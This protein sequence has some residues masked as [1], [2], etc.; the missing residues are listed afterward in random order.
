MA[1][2]EFKRLNA[3]TGFDSKLWCSF[4]S[5]FEKLA[6]EKNGIK[7]L[8]VR[9]ELFKKTVEDKGMK[10]NCLQRTQRTFRV[11][12]TMFAKQNWRKWFWVDNLTV[13]GW[14]NR[15]FFWKAEGIEIYPIVS[16]LE[17]PFA[18]GKISS[19]RKSLGSFIKNYGY[20]TLSNSLILQH[21]CILERGFGI[22]WY[23]RKSWIPR[24]SIFYNQPLRE[25]K[26]LKF[27]IGDFFC[28][29]RWSPTPGNVRSYSLHK[30][31]SKLLQWL[32]KTVTMQEKKDEQ[33]ENI[34]G[35]IFINEFME[36][37]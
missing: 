12:S 37:F 15:N 35:V 11:F 3:F 21:L 24:V 32:Q 19:L 14:E 29:S 17:V 5:Y 22:T 20:S 28:A 4:L 25:N 6:K 27:R 36:V 18:V 16:D 26:K 1:S 8:L 7:F 9:Q 34:R 30:G 2:L 23:L 13:P 31:F 10:T 33:D